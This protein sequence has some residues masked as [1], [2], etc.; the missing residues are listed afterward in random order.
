VK[1]PLW[2]AWVLVGVVTFLVYVPSLSNGWV[3]WDD[4]AN[5]IEN[6]HYRG[7]GLA[8][9]KWMSTAFVLG[10]YQPLSWVTLGLD[11][12]LWGMKAFGY[13]LTNVVLHAGSAAIFASLAA[14]VFATCRRASPRTAPGWLEAAFGCAVA[15]LWSLHPLRVEAVSWITERREVL[16]GL[17]TLLALSSHL[18]SRPLWQ[19][20]ALAALAM[21]AKVT[22]VTIPVLFV[23][24]DLWRAGW[25]GPRALARA[26]A[27]AVFRQT[28]LVLLAGAL[29]VAAF[30][31]QHESEALVSYEWL[32]FPRRLVLT[33]YGAA[34]AVLK[35]FWPSGLA[36]LHQ[37]T[38]GVTWQFLPHVWWEAGAIFALTLALAAIAWRRRALG[39]L[40]LLAAFYVLVLPT[41]GLGQSGP[42]TAAERYTY[43]PAWVLTFGI[44][45]LLA[46]WRRWPER[47]VPLIRVAAV[48]VAS[49]GALAFLSV[50]QQRVWYESETL[51]LNQIAVHPTS[52][53][54]NHQLGRHYIGRSPPRFDL[55]EPRFRAAFA[56]APSYVEPQHAL[57]LLLR[58]TN[59]PLEAID[60][61]TNLVRATPSHKD[62]WFQLGMLLWDAGRTKDAVSSFDNFVRLD[63]A[64]YAGWRVF[65]RAQAA[66][67]RPKEAVES[68]ERGIAAAGTPERGAELMADLAWLLATHPDPAVRDGRRALELAERVLA[69]RP[70]DVR[71]VLVYGVACAEA[72]EFERGIRGVELAIPRLP[73]KVEP[74]LRHLL[75]DLAKREVLRVEPTFP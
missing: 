50:R 22:A 64:N 44:G 35:T 47:P 25:L 39:T 27:R 69:A 17:L 31:A 49:L 1:L 8:N 66:A 20:W 45:L 5:F 51:W 57:G 61:F 16:C 46:T 29:V 32:S 6:E 63:R 54:G 28:P 33:V 71:T 12:E 41:G 55:A 15:L 24:I 42:Q 74:Q 4:N 72:G 19:T 52:P 11:Y 68:F 58:Q 75:D 10:H 73:P 62:T 48:L 36:V 18:R 65:A 13:H 37:S 53:T 70:P 2:T 3:D 23:L 34:F 43:Q 14:W 7:L 9:L 21:L 67:S 59:R 38:I 30:F 60:V 26:A 56:W 40:C